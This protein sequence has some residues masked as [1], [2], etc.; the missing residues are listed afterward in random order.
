[1]RP[2]P[3]AAP[4]FRGLP[5]AFPDSERGFSFEATS[6]H[7]S[8]T[9][10]VRPLLMV[11]FGA[12]GL[13]L[14]IACANVA[15]LLLA[16]AISRT[17]EIAIHTA[18]GASRLR[19]VRQVLVES[20]LLG[21]GGG[22]GGVL[23]SYW[24]T[25]VLVSMADQ[26][27]PRA[28]D[29]SVNLPVLLFALSVSTVSGLV[30]GLVPALW[31]SGRDSARALLEGRRPNS[32]RF[33]L[34]QAPSGSR[35]GRDRGL[36]HPARRRRPVDA[37]LFGPE[38]HRSRILGL[39]CADRR[40]LAGIGQP[41]SPTTRSAPSR[42]RSSNGAAKLPGVISA[43][44]VLSL[45]IGVGVS[46]RT[47]YSVEGRVVDRGTEP[48]AGLQ[49]A[50]PGYFES[51]GIPV[52]RGRAFHRRRP[53]GQPTGR[54]G[55]RGLRQSDLRPMRTRSAGASAPATRRRT[56]SS[57]SRRRSGRQHTI[58]RTR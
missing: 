36:P 25:G 15:N 47:T 52:L 27:V 41:S 26:G 45:P 13:V 9:G 23:L 50:S 22:I 20:T 30:F 29:I 4:S 54:G 21:I 1:M 28:A 38:R 14:L 34:R 55:Q 8:V 40:C 56:T 17:H 57:G 18:L 3:K 11:L 2:R 7:E 33:P 12:V 31:L 35:D 16:K 49:A 53:G 51:I 46:A 10:R 42:T 24:G 48:V 6:L 37:D 5:D 43:G 32:L 39:E 58:R 44:A 19:L